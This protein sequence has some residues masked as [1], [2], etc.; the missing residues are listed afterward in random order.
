M[1][2]ELLAD[3]EDALKGREC[4][5]ERRETG[6]VFSFGDGARFIVEAPWRIVTEVGVAHAGADDGQTFGPSPP[7][8]GEARS[9]ALIKG[10]RVRALEIDRTTADLC[11]HFDGDVRLDVFNNSSGYESWRAQFDR[12][13]EAVDLV[14]LGGG[15]IAFFIAPPGAASQVITMQLLPKP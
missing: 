10:R 8:D 12:G 5:V 7:V 15:A 1:A 13:D 2:T 9:N 14:G 6:W 11:V 3:F 4:I